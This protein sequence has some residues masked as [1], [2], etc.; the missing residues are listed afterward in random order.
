MK[1]SFLLYFFGIVA[2]Y[3]AFPNQ[4][5]HIGLFGF[6]MFVPILLLQNTEHNK[7]FK[8]LITWSFFQT[9]FIIL[10]WV[11]PFQFTER[12]ER[13]GVI[14]GFIAFYTLLPLL[15][16]LLF[17]VIFYLFKKNILIASTVWVLFEFI[18]TKLPYCFP[19]SIA[20]TQYNNLSILQIAGFTG[21]FGISFLVILSNLAISKFFQNKNPHMLILP[22]ILIASIGLNPFMENIFLPSTKQQ[23]V[24]FALIQPNLSWR[25]AWHAHKSLFLLKNAFHKITGLSAIAKQ[26]GKKLVYIWPELAASAFNLESKQLRNIL[27]KLTANQHNLILGVKGLQGN[28]ILSLNNNLEIAGKYQKTKLV[29]FF[30]TYKYIQSIY[31]KPLPIIHNSLQVGVFVCY[32][33]LYPDISRSLTLSGADF[34]G[35]LSFNTWLGNTNWP[36]LQMAY[37]PFRAAENN[38]YTFYLNNNGPS[39]V[40][41]PNGK[42][43]EILPLGKKGYILFDAFPIN[44]L[45]F[46]SRFGDIFIYCLILCLIIYGLKIGGDKL[47]SNST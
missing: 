13:M 35:G 44:T 41:R 39:G 26:D 22:T 43:I 2:C 21:I 33:M 8:F 14:F 7:K 31:Q 29:P 16:A 37:L 25:E 17:E 20:I 10:L 36:L 19:L 38:R 47:K 32:E 18:M 24:K 40:A 6:F 15:T 42:I 4:H 3:T 11:N 1:I 9:F 30:E 5:I 28:A 46:Y 27:K 23:A 34:L 12:F 45:S